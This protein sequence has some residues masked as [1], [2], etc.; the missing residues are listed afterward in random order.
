MGT[1]VKWGDVYRSNIA[2]QWFDITD[3]QAGDYT[4]RVVADPA[5][6]GLPNGFFEESNESNNDA[7][8]KIR[9][10]TSGVTVL[11]KSAEP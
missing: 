8:V 6:A 2:F 3:V 5:G 1:S 11:S 4:L 10:G 7:W 9:I